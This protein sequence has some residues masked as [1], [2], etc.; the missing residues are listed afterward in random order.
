MADGLNDTE[1][2]VQQ[3]CKI[4]ISWGKDNFLENIWKPVQHA[5]FP[6]ITSTTQLDTKQVSE[7]YE[8]VN[9]IMGEQWG[10]SKQF[11]SYEQQLNNSMVSDE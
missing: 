10:V 11:P 7:I 3:V 8:Q 1:A 9:K 5:M 2:S 6:E 4:P